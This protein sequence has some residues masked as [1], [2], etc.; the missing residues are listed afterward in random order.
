MTDHV[1]AVFAAIHPDRPH[2]GEIADDLEA[3]GETLPDEF[4][5]ETPAAFDLSQLQDFF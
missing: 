4:E 3:E 5:D 2:D 1:P